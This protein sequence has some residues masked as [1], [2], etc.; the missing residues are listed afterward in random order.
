MFLGLAIFI[1]A[2]VHMRPETSHLPELA[3]FFVI[4]LIGELMPIR[5][6]G[7][8]M[9]ITV[10][11]PTITGLFLSHGSGPTLTLAP[12]GIFIGVVAVHRS[13]NL[14]WVLNMC[15]YNT[16][17][18]IIPIAVMCWVY[19][20][21]GG[22]TLDAG[23]EVTLSSIFLPLFVAL[24]AS[25]TANALLFITGLSLARRDPWRLSFAQNSRWFA[26]D[27]IITGPS[28]ILFA[29]MYMQF[30]IY[31][32]LLIIIPFILGRQS[33]KIYSEQMGAYLETVT[34]LGSYM[35]HYHP[36][37]KGHL[38]RVANTSDR[39]A[40]QMGLPYQS[41]M[42]IREAGL[43]HDIGKVGVS[44]EILDKVGQ[45]SDEDWATI[46]QHPARGAEILAQM[47]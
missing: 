30:D 18:C 36:Y 11:I 9:D 45:L 40:K 33:L 26:P 24:A 12:L 4:I 27:Y 8:D 22:K 5:V 28:G 21:V 34:T 6:P 37:T 3:V 13:H 25:T 43:L 14:K 16:A 39:I 19:H 20:F 42:F 47:K 44:E 1:W 29:M 2:L 38:E 23:P 35:Q 32:V 7:S 46:K 10:T 15:S 31:G 41:L 17:T